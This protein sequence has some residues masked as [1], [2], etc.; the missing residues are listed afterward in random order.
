VLAF[1]ECLFYF[2]FLLVCEVCTFYI[3]VEQ[4]YLLTVW[5]VG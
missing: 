5:R 1:V 4:E 2:I 3:Q